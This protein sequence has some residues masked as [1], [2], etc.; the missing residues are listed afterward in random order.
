MLAE[1]KPAMAT[2]LLKL[3]GTLV[4]P[5][6]LSPHE[7]TVPSFFKARVWK[8]PAEM[9]TTLLKPG[10][11]MVSPSSLYPQTITGPWVKRAPLGEKPAD[12]AATPLNPAGTFVAS[13]PWPHA[14]TVRSLLRARSKPPPTEMA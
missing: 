12:T 6:L 10:G 2:T 11:I 4:A 13:P 8:P 5:A 7:T 9:A 3:A 1:F 14:A